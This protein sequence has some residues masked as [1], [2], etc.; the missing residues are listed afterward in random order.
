M[1]Q[2]ELL[3]VLHYDIRFFIFDSTVR[4][5]AVSNMLDDVPPQVSYFV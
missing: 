2:E 5:T 4:L 3:K 1:A